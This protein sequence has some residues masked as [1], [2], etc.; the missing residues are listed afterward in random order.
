MKRSRRLQPKIHAL[1]L[2][3]GFTHHDKLPAIELI[4]QR[5]V[6]VIDSFQKPQYPVFNR[7]GRPNHEAYRTILSAAIF[8]A[9]R[10][11]MGEKAKISKRLPGAAPNPFVVFATA[12]YRLLHISN[13]ID[14][15]D[16]YR[17]LGNTLERN[18]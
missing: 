5:A 10:V 17:S 14:N 16:H 2:S 11:G 3:A 15:L 7:V 13:V 9:W 18:S 12:V 1:V 4:L 6:E 8:R